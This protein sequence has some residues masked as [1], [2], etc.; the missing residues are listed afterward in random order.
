MKEKLVALG[1]PPLNIKPNDVQN[2]VV[3]E[4][5]RWAVFVDKLNIK[6]KK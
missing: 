6:E 5:Q 4:R 3:T 1:T 2:Y